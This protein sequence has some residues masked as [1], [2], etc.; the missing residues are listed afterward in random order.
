VLDTALVK[1]LSS[2]ESFRWL[3]LSG[4]HAPVPRLVVAA[5]TDEQPVNSTAAYACAS[6]IIIDII[7]VVLLSRET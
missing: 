3:D 6:S 4:E 2:M 5:Q 1:R 7:E